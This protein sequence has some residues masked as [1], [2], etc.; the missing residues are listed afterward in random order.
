MRALIIISVSRATV[1][2]P[3]RSSAT[4][5][6]TRSL[7]RSRVS[8][9]RPTFPCSRI[10]SSSETSAPVVNAAAWPLAACVS[11]IVSALRQSELRPQLVHLVSVTERRLQDLIELLVGL[12]RPAQIGELCPEIQQLTQWLHLL[13]DRIG[14]EVIHAAEIEIDRELR[15]IRVF[16]QLVLDA[17]REVRLHAC[18]H[19][20]EVI[21]R[22]LDEL[23]LLQLRQRF[24]RLAAEVTQH[25]HEERKFLLF[26][27][28]AG[29]H[30]VR[31]RDAR[32]ANALEFFLCAVG[33]AGTPGVG[34]ARRQENWGNC[35]R[36]DTLAVGAGG[37][38][39][40]H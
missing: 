30:L 37:R 16:G 1:I 4:N 12:Q 19:V 21:R 24:R 11:A 34:W 29:F 15:R 39:P 3:S 40:P 36:Q 25:A 9:S 38:L 8:V 22:H 26:D 10:W 13:R 6:L 2:E 18:Q 23:A 20:V 7:P 31:D 14:R 28:A 27:R 17:E 5:R 35:R 32:R 33:H